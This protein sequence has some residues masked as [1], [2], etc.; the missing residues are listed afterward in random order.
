M[1]VWGAFSVAQAQAATLLQQPNGTTNGNATST[2]QYFRIGQGNLIGQVPLS[3]TGVTLRAKGTFANGAEYFGIQIIGYSDAYIT[4]TDVCGWN[5]TP[6]AV[7]LGA[8]D[9]TF[10]A[11]N[12]GCSTGDG[13]YSS[14]QW[15]EIIFLTNL[16]SVTWVGLPAA[17]SPFMP[18]SPP[19]GVLGITPYV[20]VSGVNQSL[21][22]NLV[23]GGNPS[24]VST[25]TIRAYCNGSYATSTG[26]F[27]DIANGVT[28]GTC[29]AFAFLFVPN[30]DTLQSF[31]DLG[32]TT[33][34]KIPF[35]YYYDFAGI[36]NGSTAS[37]STNFNALSTDLRATGVASTTAF[38]N[39]LPS[40]FTWLSTT[41][42]STYVNPTL[43]A[44]LFLLMRSAIWIAVLFHIYHRLVPKKATHV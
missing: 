14:S 13:I 39:V 35:S 34:N 26:F 11:N 16:G 6:A 25:S 18:Y 8:F 23:N 4:A 38:A 7:G 24:G 36:L 43:Y 41:T 31:S 30:Q 12:N 15:V 40:T 42:I 27:S 3:G 33:Q 9:G 19:E 37:S 28:Y 20:V 10:T 17:V 22:P 2:N 29:T 32:S 44:L 1:L 5:I 21:D